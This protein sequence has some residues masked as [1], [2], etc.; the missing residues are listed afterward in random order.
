[1]RVD[2]F[3]SQTGGADL[4]INGTQRSRAL[5]VVDLAAPSG[6]FNTTRPEGPNGSL[7]S[8]FG[9][10]S[11]AAPHVA[12]LSL[13]VK[14]YLLPMVP[15]LNYP[16]WLHT[17]ML[18]MGDR[19]DWDS[20]NLSITQRNVGSS[21]VYG[22]GKIKLRKFIPGHFRYLDKHWTAGNFPGTYYSERVF[23]YPST[24]SHVFIKAVMN[25]IEFLAN[26]DPL[27]P[28]MASAFILRLYQT[29]QTYGGLCPSSYETAC[30]GGCT[31]VTDISY[32]VKKMVSMTAGPGAMQGRCY[33]VRLN[34][35]HITSRGA[36]VQLVFYRSDR[37]DHQNSQN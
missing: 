11:G 8:F 18:A 29:N 31:F 15:L 23:P 1:M 16:G 24:S 3:A 34:K 10:S 35:R 20:T 7:N 12:G 33:Y 9:G 37:F 6:G 36:S 14:H 4:I 13:L 17:T 19:S 21:R 26:E 22:F 27:D 30:A 25:Q 28:D 32:D 5:S 2:P